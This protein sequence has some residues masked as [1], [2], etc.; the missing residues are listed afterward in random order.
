MSSRIS[1]NYS[2]NWT[3]SQ[4]FQSYIFSLF[5]FLW[6][7]HHSDHNTRNMNE[8]TKASSR[9]SNPVKPPP[10]DKYFLEECFI[11]GK[12]WKTVFSLFYCFPMVQTYFY[13]WFSSTNTVCCTFSFKYNYK[14]NASMVATLRLCLLWKI[15]QWYGLSDDIDSRLL[16]VAIR[17]AIPGFMPLLSCVT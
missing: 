6:I 2:D 14:F 13:L 16:S 3:Y 12:H 1:V 5:F 10:S 4:P 11:Q 17:K 15:S 9:L 7:N 8:E